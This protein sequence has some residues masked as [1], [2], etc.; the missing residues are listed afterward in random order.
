M[1]QRGA[2]QPAALLR[3]PVHFNRDQ[4]GEDG[5]AVAVAGGEG[6]LGIDHL[7][8]SRGDVVEIILVDGTG[9]AQRFELDDALAEVGIDQR[10]P[11]AFAGRDRDEG[12]DDARIEPGAGAAADL[13]DRLVAA[14]AHVEDIDDLGEQRDARE[15]RDLAGMLALGQALAVPLLVEID[16]AL[17]DGFGEPHAPGDIGAAMAARLGQLPGDLAGLERGLD[18][19]AEAVGDGLAHAGIGD[20]EFEELRR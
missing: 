6:G 1:E 15:D 9:F 18:D 5:D 19:G 2:V 20:Q 7:G 3:G 11:E 8:E 14:L 16:D 4:I 12:I 17:R 10:G 13:G